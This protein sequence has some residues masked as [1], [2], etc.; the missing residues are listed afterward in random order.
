MNGSGL[1][2]LFVQLFGDVVH[3]LGDFPKLVQHRAESL[4]NPLEQW[5]TSRE[6]RG[7]LGQDLPTLSV[8]CSVGAC[9]G[10]IAD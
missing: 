5:T 3:R 7:G 8:L 9:C 2:A 4:D 6:I 1:V 10:T